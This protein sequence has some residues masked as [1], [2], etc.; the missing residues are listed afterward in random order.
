V[1]FRRRF[2]DD[3][4][5]GS[6]LS[7]TIPSLTV[8]FQRD[9][10]VFVDCLGTKQKPWCCFRCSLEVVLRLGIQFGSLV[11]CFDCE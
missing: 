6:E 10:L 1:W 9:L 5:R 7:L 11:T 8:F 3:Q 2:F 4:L